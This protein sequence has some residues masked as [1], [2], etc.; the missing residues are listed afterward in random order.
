MIKHS[1]S[2][3]CYVSPIVFKNVLVEESPLVPLSFLIHERKHAKWHQ[4]LFKY[5]KDKIPLVDKKKIPFVDDQEPGLKKAIQEMFPTCPIM[6]CWNHLKGDFKFWLKRKVESDNIK[7][8]V[9]HVDKMLHCDSKEELLELKSNLT[10][11]W[12][13]VVL[14]HFNKFVSPSIQYHSG[15]WVI[16][17]YPGMF[18][19]YSG[20]TNNLSESM[21]AVL[22]RENDWKELP[23]DLLALGF[24]YIQNF[25]NYE[26]LHGRSGMG[27]YHLKAELKRA[28]I[29]TSD[30]ILPKKSSLSRRGN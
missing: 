29:P 12:T 24:Y 17:E 10:S 21:N 1:I 16:E 15:K 3:D 19:P 18:Y 11:K 7:V 28:F 9:D 23:V 26:I 5:L 8:Y 4:L 20:I 30:L 13:P 14:E 2:V 6:F 27:N 25:E 22:K